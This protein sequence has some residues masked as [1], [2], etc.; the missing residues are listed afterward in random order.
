[1]NI[2]TM[3][4]EVGGNFDQQRAVAQLSGLFGIFA[5]L[6]TS[7]G[8]YGVTAYTVERGTSEIGIRMAVGAN[9]ADILFLILRGA[10]TQIAFGLAL[11]IPVAVLIGKLL[12]SRVYEVGTLDPI[13]LCT[14]MAALL[15]CAFI[16]SV[17]P[18][19]RAASIQ[20]LEALRTE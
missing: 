4:Q 9:R 13:A 5:L 16:A 11:G 15:L 12:G 17:I 18:A 7:I 19:W 3:Q 6:L 8:L 20:P 14:A 1:M 10:F 2:Q